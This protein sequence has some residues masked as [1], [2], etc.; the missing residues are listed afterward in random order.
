MEMPVA[1]SLDRERARL[2]EGV[3]RFTADLSRHGPL[4]VVLED[5][6][7][8]SESTL[9]MLHYLARHLAAHSV[10]IVGTFRPEALTI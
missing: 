1:A 9:Q 3:T 2:F 5:L 4:L 8:A 10:L 7:W 6:H